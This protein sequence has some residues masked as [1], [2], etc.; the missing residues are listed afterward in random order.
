LRTTAVFDAEF[1]S[2]FFDVDITSN[3]AILIMV[4]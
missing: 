4:M 2:P 1:T 3:L